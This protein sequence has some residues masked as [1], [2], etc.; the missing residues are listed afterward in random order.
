MLT[1]QRSDSALGAGAPLDEFDEVVGGLDLLAGLARLSLAQDRNE[2]DTELGQLVVNRCL[3]VAAIRSDS[4]RDDT[5][6]GDRSRDRGGETWRVGWHPCFD[7]VVDNDPVA[8]VGDLAGVPN[9]VGV[10]RLPLRIGL[11]SSS[12]SDTRRVLPAGVSP[13]RRTLVCRITWVTASIRWARSASIRRS[14]FT[15]RSPIR[16]AFTRTRLACSTAVSARSASLP[17][18]ASTS[19]LASS[20]RRR[21]FDPIR[22]APWRAIAV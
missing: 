19:A 20:V 21:N 16:C 13:A 17:V 15:G 7:L 14:R 10:A 5:G 9:W 3:S 22:C 4:V 18:I 1:F 8:V 2:L 11:A 12:W 6:G